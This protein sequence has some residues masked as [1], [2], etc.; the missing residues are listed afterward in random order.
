[1]KDR[2]LFNFVIMHADDHTLVI[3]IDGRGEIRRA[4]VATLNAIETEKALNESSFKTIQVIEKSDNLC[5][6]FMNWF[7]RKR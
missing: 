1:L 4:R 5:E 2:Q 6:A 7:E 3:S